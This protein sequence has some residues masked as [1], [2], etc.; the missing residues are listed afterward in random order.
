MVIEPLVK[1][2][3]LTVLDA[4][5]GQSGYLKVGKV[6]LQRQAFFC[7]FKGFSHPTALLFRD[8]HVEHRLMK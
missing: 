3:Y 8:L 6:L 5:S 4:L 7:S 1:L 2:G